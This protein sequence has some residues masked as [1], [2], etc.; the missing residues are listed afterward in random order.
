MQVQQ[1]EINRQNAEHE[2]EDLAKKQEAEA[3]AKKVEDEDAHEK[4]YNEA[5]EALTQYSDD[6]NGMLHKIIAGEVPHVKW[7]T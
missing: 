7:E 2:A 1:E 3:E 4:R 5:F 6:V